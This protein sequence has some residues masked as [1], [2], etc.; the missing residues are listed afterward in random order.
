[1]S[2]AS[3]AGKNYKVSFD[4]MLHFHPSYHR[5]VETLQRFCNNAAVPAQREYGQNNGGG[6]AEN[7]QN[8]DWTLL[9]LLSAAV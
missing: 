1:M 7:K 2:V 4:E 3:I 5:N 8:T 9:M 6:E